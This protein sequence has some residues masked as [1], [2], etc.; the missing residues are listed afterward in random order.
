M[1][2]RVANETGTEFVGKGLHASAAAFDA[3]DRLVTEQAGL[4]EAHRQHCESLVRSGQWQKLPA[5]VLAGLPHIGADLLLSLA[6]R[7]TK[8]E[9][10]SEALYMWR[11]LAKCGAANVPFRHL[12]NAQL[13]CAAKLGLAIYH[14]EIPE[15]SDASSSADRSNCG[16]NPRTHNRN[17]RH[18]VVAGIPFCGSTLL[19]L[20]LGSLP[21][22]ANVGESHWLI[23]KRLQRTSAV[24][25]LTPEGYEQCMCCGAACPIVTA[26]LRHLLADATVDFYGALGAAYAA[27]TVLTSDKYYDHMLRLDPALHNDAIVLFRHPMANWQSHRVRNPAGAAGDGQRRYLKKWADAHVA[28]LQYFDNR[29]MKIFLDF[30]EFTAHPERSLEL[31]CRKLSLRFDPE[32]LAYW[33]SEQHYVGGNMQLAHRRHEADVSE[34]RIGPRSTQTIAKPA[35]EAQ[36]EFTRALRVWEK[37]RE[38]RARSLGG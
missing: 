4:P 13:D 37:L 6:K 38:S 30:D 33:R 31:L 12:V 21:G 16:R 7:A 29:G 9:Q 23:E 22:I 5:A 2:P 8:Q 36:D 32:A 1:V 34:L 19:G 10:W 27:D 24:P 3:G 26:D 18:I 14:P 35:P 25:P 20:V 28:F 15:L 17:P 11:L